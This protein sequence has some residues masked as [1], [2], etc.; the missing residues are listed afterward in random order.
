MRAV[1]LSKYGELLKVK[2]VPLPVLKSPSD[3][4]IKVKYAP[5][6]PADIYFSFGVY[7]IRPPLP[8]T[9]G[10]EGS[11]T[12]VESLGHKDLIGKRVAFMVRNESMGSFAEFTVSSKNLVI[13]LRETDKFEDNSCLFVNPFTAIGFREI[14][15][16]GGH[17]AIIL[18]ASNSALCRMVR[19]LAL[20]DKVKTINIVRKEEQIKGILAEGGDFALNS[21]SPAYEKSLQSAIEEAKPSCFFDAVGGKLSARIFT[22][23]PPKS[24]CY[25]YGALSHSPIGEIEAHN[26]VFQ[27]K[28]FTGFW[29]KQWLISQRDEQAFREIKR[30]VIENDDFRARIAGIHKIERI[31]QAL[32]EYRS[33]MSQGK[34]LLDLD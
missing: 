1:S 32:K 20:K 19:S 30:E 26:Y 9:I 4:L 2:T 18:T 27:Q 33:N 17:K 6:N 5:I 29:L 10:M 21:E 22:L 14:I 34:I 12:V 7:G 13:E 24:L 31:G 15:R 8:V 11:G 16:S 3:L 23:M 25:S 28:T